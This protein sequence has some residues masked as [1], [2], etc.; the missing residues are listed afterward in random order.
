MILCLKNQSQPQYKCGNGRD[1]DNGNDAVIIALK[2]RP[3]L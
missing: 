1:C 2:Y 3:E